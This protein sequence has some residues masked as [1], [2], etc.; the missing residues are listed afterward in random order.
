[1]IRILRN[2]MTN[3]WDAYYTGAERVQV[4]ALFNTAVLPTAFTLRMPLA[5]VV[6]RIQALNPGSEV[7]S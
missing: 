1:M 7:V 5:D 2:E 6:A 3:T 4:I